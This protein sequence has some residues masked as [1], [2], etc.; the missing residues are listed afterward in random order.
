MPMNP[1]KLGLSS[2][3][4]MGVAV[5]AF[6]VS[7][8]SEQGSAVRQLVI[9]RLVVP[10]ADGTRFTTT[11]HTFVVREGDTL[12]KIILRGGAVDSELMEF[13][14]R[15][16]DARRLFELA[17]GEQLHARIDSIGRVQQL[18]LS[19]GEDEIDLDHRQGKRLL[20]RRTHDGLRA[21]VETIDLIRNSRIGYGRVVSSLFATTAGAHI[22]DRV[23]S[24]IVDVL[25]G[26]INFQ[27]DLRQGD[28]LRV[29]YETLTEPDRLDVDYAGK[30]LAVELKGGDRAY[31][32]MWLENDDGSG[33]YYDFEGRA[34]RGF[35]RFPIEYAR[36]SSGFTRGR[37][38]P[39]LHRN[40]PHRGV[41][42]V[43]APGT[44]IRA[45]GN[46][47]IEFIGEQ[48]GYGRV[49]ILR[50]TQGVS[51]VYA[52]MR[53]F[54]KGLKQGQSVH[55]GDVIGY[56]GASGWATGPHLHYE[57]RVDGHHKNPL[58][59][60]LPEAHPLPDDMRQVH[61]QRAL[62]LQAQLEQIETIQLA[63]RFE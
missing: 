21:D 31:S 37:W 58:T 62:Q 22:P 42:F 20:V 19:L 8:P 59:V 12:E 40:V 2:L 23:A 30:L 29:L 26:E 11:D 55:Q 46:G 32:A 25:G 53:G 60:A 15:N 34:S 49:I 16:E 9:D 6:G 39:I 41:D 52:H 47:T 1:V 63:G 48:R 28:E 61:A 13:V 56:V 35:L 17:P 33:Q 18:R 44:K 4:A 50:H 14:A 5:T 27:R 10:A 3:A 7:A 51:T 45:S 38:H 54:A 43:A 36:I 24:Q 57:Y